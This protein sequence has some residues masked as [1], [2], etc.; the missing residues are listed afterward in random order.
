MSGNKILAFVFGCER[1]FISQKDVLLS[2]DLLSAWAIYF[3][4]TDT[5]KNEV[6]KTGYVLSQISSV[7]QKYI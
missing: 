3:A 7:F 4:N 6:F 5:K 1:D 2:P